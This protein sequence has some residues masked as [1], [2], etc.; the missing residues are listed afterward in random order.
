MRLRAAMAAVVLLSAAVVWAEQEPDLPIDVEV[1]TNVV[2]GEGRP[3]VKLTAREPVTNVKVTVKRSGAPV[4]R[5]RVKALG[6]GGV[7]VFQWNERPGIYDYGVT[8]E[9]R[10]GD[11]VMS[12]AFNMGLAYLEPLKMVLTRDRVDLAKRQLY[13][14]MNH[15]AE[16]ASL[17]VEAPDGRVLA[18]VE[19]SYDGAAPGSKLLVRWPEVTHAIGRMELEAHSVTG[20]WVGMELLPWSVSIPHEE[21]VFE[22]DQW[23]IRP[24]EAPKLDRAIELIHKA[25]REH[26]GEMV[27]NLYVGGFTDTVGTP[28]HNRTLS[29]NRAREIARYFKSHNV[30]LPIYYRGFG[31]DVPAVPPPDEIDEPRNRRA[32]YVLGAQPPS[33][34]KSVGWGGWKRL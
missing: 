17:V 10:H 27:V 5:F 12:Q 20:H 30:T 26:A 8:V 29:E 18:R 6:A 31:E 13:F 2:V 7:K 25:L 11:T 9:A 28:A 21:V 24:S 23:E 33:L 3:F 34:A 32:I 14:Q 4:K 16:R 19:E 22:T 1:A 15:P